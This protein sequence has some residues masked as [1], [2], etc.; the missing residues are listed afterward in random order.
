VVRLPGKNF[1]FRR[2]LMLFRVS[3]DTFWRLSAPPLRHFWL[4]VEQSELV[5]VVVGMCCKSKDECGVV[6]ILAFL[7]T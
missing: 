6:A 4:E 5:A 2:A 7:S 1:G 3:C